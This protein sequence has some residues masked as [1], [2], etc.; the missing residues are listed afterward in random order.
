M[1][2]DVGHKEER[3]PN[4]VELGSIATPCGRCLAF[5]NSLQH[6][7][8]LL[9]NG[10]DTE[11]VTR[12]VLIFWL[13]DPDQRILS[14]LDVP[15]SSGTSLCRSSRPLFDVSGVQSRGSSTTQLLLGYCSS[16]NGV[17]PTRRRSAT[18]RLS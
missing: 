13:V 9:W 10:S 15:G 3:V 14:T 1:G 12:K 11:T 18:E 6:K 8:E 4:H 2:W 17:S 7:V 5:K 16:P